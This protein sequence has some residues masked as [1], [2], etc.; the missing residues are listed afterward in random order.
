MRQIT[1]AGAAL[2]IATAF[3]CSP[4][5]R[6]ETASN[7]NTAADDISDATR[8]GAADVKDAVRDGAD[9][10]SDEAHDAREYAYA[11]RKDFRRDVDLQLKNLD[12]EIAELERDTKRGADKVRDS[13]L[14]NIHVARK[15]VTRD[16]NRLGN[17]TESNWDD[18]KREVNQSVYSLSEAVRRQRPDARPM[19]GTGP[20]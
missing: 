5:D 20:S 3:A 16:L 13:T 15:A 17:A 4:R 9:E 1:Y 2:L 10:V 19:G 7:A 14:A 6:Q 11:E 12:A 18:L 8:K